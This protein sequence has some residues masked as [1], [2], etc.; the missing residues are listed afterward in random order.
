MTTTRVTVISQRGRLVATQ[1]PMPAPKNSAGPT[2]RLVAGPGQRSHELEL[3]DAEAYHTRA[4][5]AE[6]HHIV[7]RRLKLK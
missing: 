5:V 4:A 6:L 1:I 2:A 7:K 3:D